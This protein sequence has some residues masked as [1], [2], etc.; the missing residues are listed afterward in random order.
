MSRPVVGGSSFLMRLSVENREEKL[1]ELIRAG[2]AQHSVRTTAQ[3]LGDRSK[4]VGMSDIG[5]YL[6]CQRMAV[7]NRLHPDQKDKS[8]S[9]MLTLS[10]GHWF[11]NGI[12]SVLEELNIP[13]IRQLEIGIDHEDGVEIHA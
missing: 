3:S 7:L 5:S 8:L 9:K 10:R 2:L 1:L 13:H 6:T 12:A 11:E 4:Y